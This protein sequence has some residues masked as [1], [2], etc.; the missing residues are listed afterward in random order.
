MPVCPNN[1]NFTFHIPQDSIQSTIGQYDGSQWTFEPAPS[2]DVQ[3]KHQIANFVDFCN[4]CGNCDVF[5]PELGGP[6]KL[7]PRFH[8]SLAGWQAESG[9]RDGFFITRGSEADEVYA[10]IQLQEY[11][12]VVRGDWVQ[13]AG[14]SFEVR[15]QASDPEGSLEGRSEGSV[16]LALYRLI[17]LFRLGVLE[18]GGANYISAEAVL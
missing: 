8:G 5:C 1:A 9:A 11:H 6:Y 15:F 13:F 16:D 17:D 10:R 18:R 2:L 12:L 7:K 3:E 14:A 4:D